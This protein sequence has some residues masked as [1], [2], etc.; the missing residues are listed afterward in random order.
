MRTALACLLLLVLA[1]AAAA[2]SDCTAADVWA[3]AQR[4]MHVAFLYRHDGADG[5][6]A[7]LA[8]Y[9]QL[10][11][12]GYAHP[13]WPAAWQVDTRLAVDAHLLSNSTC[14]AVRATNANASLAIAEADAFLLLSAL[15]RYK[16]FLA[17]GTL[18]CADPYSYPIY[19]E[20]TGQLHCA[21]AEGKTCTTMDD[22]AVAHWSTTY[23][24]AVVVIVLTTAIM[25]GSAIAS[26]IYLHCAIA[27]VDTLQTAPAKTASK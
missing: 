24:L 14:D 20:L 17:T 8:Y 15:L 25:L 2:A 16:A 26:S 23:T 19:D 18:G 4:D 21:C 3:F 1:A 11:A 7:A 22:E 13:Y 6:A 5:I 12:V 27:A 9:R 10:D